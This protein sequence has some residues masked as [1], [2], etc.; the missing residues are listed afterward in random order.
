[1][2]DMTIQAITPSANA[3]IDG[4]RFFAYGMLYATGRTV[5][6]DLVAA[7]KWFNL[8]ALSGNRDAIRW[9]REI[10]AEMSAAEIAAAQR[11][12]RLDPTTTARTSL[13]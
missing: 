10:A 1:M 8:A 4:D 9:R 6:R 5:S 7:H 2:T 11:A 12:A 3:R 13:P